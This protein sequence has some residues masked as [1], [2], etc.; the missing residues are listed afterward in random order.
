MRGGGPDG[1]GRSFAGG[2]MGWLAAARGPAEANLRRAMVY[3]SAVASFCCEGFRPDSDHAGQPR[4][5]RKAGQG[6]WN[7]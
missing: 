1:R 4:G 2:M 3:G 6:R 7:H 5:H